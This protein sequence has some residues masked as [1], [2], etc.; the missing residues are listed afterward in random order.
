MRAAFLLSR[1]RSLSAHPKYKHNGKRKYEIQ[2][3]G[4]ILSVEQMAASSE[5]SLEEIQV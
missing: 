3:H 4:S 2:T 1:P 5:R